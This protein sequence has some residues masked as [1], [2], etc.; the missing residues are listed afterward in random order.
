MLLAWHLWARQNFVFLWVLIS[1]QWQYYDLDFNGHHEIGMEFLCMSNPAFFSTHLDCNRVFDRFMSDRW[2]TFFWRCIQNFVWTKD[3][4]R[5]SC[6]CP[7]LVRM[8]I[9]VI[10]EAHLQFVHTSFGGASI[11]SMGFVWLYLWTMKSS[12]LITWYRVHIGYVRLSLI[13]SKFQFGNNQCITINW[14]VLCVARTA[15]PIRLTILDK[16]KPHSSSPI[17]SVYCLNLPKLPSLPI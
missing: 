16:T 5:Y 2:H 1:T 15:Q 4:D 12:I 14:C 11:S 9:L 17:L 10:Q 3:V 6:L 8:L 13:P 7:Q